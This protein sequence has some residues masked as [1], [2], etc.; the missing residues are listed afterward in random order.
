MQ[1]E[2]VTTEELIDELN[3]RYPVLVLLTLRT[4]KGAKDEKA[5][6]FHSWY[7]GGWNACF[8]LVARMAAR[9][10]QHEQQD[11]VHQSD[12]DREPGEGTN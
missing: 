3:R 1:L 2:F 5:E 12:D 11:T 7:R 6:S 4:A 9:F 10:A 8:G